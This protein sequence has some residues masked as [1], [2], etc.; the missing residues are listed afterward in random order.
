MVEFFLEN[1]NKLSA[2]VWDNRLGGSVVS[3]YIIDI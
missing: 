2:M 3:I 1:R